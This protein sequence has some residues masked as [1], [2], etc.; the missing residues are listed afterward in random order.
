M[1]KKMNKLSGYLV[2]FDKQ[3]EAFNSIYD[4]VLYK[5]PKDSWSL[6]GG[7][8]LS[9]FYFQNRLS[10]DI[11]IFINDPQYFSFLSPKWYIDESDI[12]NNSYQELAN[13]IK[14]TTKKSIKIDFL[15]SP[16]LT[17]ENLKLKTLPNIDFDFFVD[18][19]DEIIAKK[20]KY[21]KEDNLARDIFDI[22]ISLK[23]DSTLL[24]RLYNQDIILLE[25]IILWQNI[26]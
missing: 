25:D 9:I 13:H 5:I 24:S 14:L 1:A 17:K 6:G 16:P 23:K 12:F 2:N 10:F 11:D 20:I 18:S 7:T 21:R 4:E 26:I 3:I 8:A 22:A 19:V 15:L